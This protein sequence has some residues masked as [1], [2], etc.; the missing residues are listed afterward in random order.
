MPVDQVLKDAVADAGNKALVNVVE[1]IADQL[2]ATMTQGRARITHSKPR[3]FSTGDPE[4]WFNFL[5]HFDEVAATNQWNDE[6]KKRQLKTSL[7]GDAMSQA[8]HV[9]NTGPLMTYE[10]F[11]ELLEVTFLPPADS[12]S[13]RGKY[14]DASQTI[15]ETALQW[16]SRLRNLHLRAW[17]NVANLDT[18]QDLIHKYVSGL[19]NPTIYTKVLEANP[20][21]F[22]A[23]LT[24]AQNQEAVVTQVKARMEANRGKSAA[25]YALLAGLDVDQAL[26]QFG[27]R[28]P[29]P[30][31]KAPATGPGQVRRCFECN[32]LEH[33]VAECPQRDRK[34]RAFGRNKPRQAARGSMRGGPSRG[35]RRSFARAPGAGRRPQVNQ[36][37]GDE[38]VG[39]HYVDVSKA[40]NE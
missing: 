10:A 28:K 7:D 21:T 1:A 4:D 20:G 2:A 39:H 5:C 9:V 37:D 24:M 15:N 22:Q 8:R 16:H 25:N 36:L 3:T 27:S 23:A 40:G 18:A 35:G 38:E 26:N 6:E 17:G 30:I 14:Y 13:T 32:S 33:L 29:N 34:V 11:K 19:H 12:Q 31:R